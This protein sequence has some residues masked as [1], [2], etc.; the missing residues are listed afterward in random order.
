MSLQLSY[1]KTML[2]GHLKGMTVQAGFNCPT[3]RDAKRSKK[4][5]A[6]YTEDSPGTDISGNRFTVSNIKI[7][8][9][10]G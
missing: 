10:H 2:S 5:L 4:S 9:C 6:M 3:P 8:E 1:D 7:E